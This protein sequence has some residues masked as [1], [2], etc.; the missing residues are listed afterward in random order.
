MI[1]VNTTDFT[2]PKPGDTAR[3]ARPLGGRELDG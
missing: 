3:G 1:K 2:P